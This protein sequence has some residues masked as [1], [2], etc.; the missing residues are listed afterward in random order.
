M[1]LL[2]SLPLH[3]GALSEP[4]P[5][6]HLHQLVAQPRE[7]SGR[8]PFRQPRRRAS[9]VQPGFARLIAVASAAR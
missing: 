7:L 9:L 3:L 4:A 5:E 8:A 2:L 6:E 1:S